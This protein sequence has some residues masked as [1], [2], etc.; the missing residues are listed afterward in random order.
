M[1]PA[2][3]GGPPAAGARGRSA[4]VD[5][6]HERSLQGYARFSGFLYLFVMAAFV[7][8]LLSLG[9]IGVPG[10]F[11]RTAQNAADA[12]LLY[13]LSLACQL[14]GAVAIILLAWAQWVLLRRVNPELAL[15]A[16]VFRAAEGILIAP[17]MGVKFAQLANYTGPRD[18]AAHEILR[19][20]FV[21]SFN[22]YL[23]YWAA[24]SAIFYWLF[25][26]SRLVPRW[27]ALYSLVGVALSSLTIVAWGPLLAPEMSAALPIWLWGLLG[28]FEVVIGL[29]LLVRGADFRW[30]NSREVAPAER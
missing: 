17:N 29:W 13:R 2:E 10:D 28:G 24:G 1:T 22:I 6:A 23:I 5:Q 4:T 9:G 3:L 14:V 25:Y 15:L 27:L 16:L 30:W 12:E 21:A 19:G 11:A 18:A 26:R 8:P 7:A 20:E